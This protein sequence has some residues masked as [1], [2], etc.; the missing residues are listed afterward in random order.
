M[1]AIFQSLLWD[2][3]DDT[4][5]ATQSHLQGAEAP[6][7]QVDAVATLFELV[8]EDGTP[9]NHTA[10]TRFQLFAEDETVV[11]TSCFIFK[12]PTKGKWSRAT[13]PSNTQPKPAEPPVPKSPAK[14]SRDLSP[15]DTRPDHT[16]PSIPQSQK[17]KETGFVAPR[18]TTRTLKD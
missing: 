17:E 8:D 6:I 4:N 11:N 12:S 15:P 14:E 13:A 9:A 2:I 1:N 7:S 3:H 16:D 18:D 5:Q 10:A